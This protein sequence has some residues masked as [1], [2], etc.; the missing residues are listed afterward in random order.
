MKKVKQHI[1]AIGE[2]T[3]HSHRFQTLS[4]EAWLKVSEELRQIEIDVAP[5]ELV[6]EEHSEVLFL[7]GVKYKQYQMREVDPFTN[8]LRAVLD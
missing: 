2:H 7:P 6:H 8:E 4:K 1:A 3:N 5:A